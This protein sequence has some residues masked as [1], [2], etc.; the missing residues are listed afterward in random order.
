[1]NISNLDLSQIEENSA[2]AA[3][4]LK[5]LSNQQRL[6]ILA[7]LTQGELSVGE[8]E[9]RLEISQSSLSQH[10]ARLRSQ[11]VVEFRKQSTTVYYRL[12]DPK[13]L[14]ILE[15]LWGLYQPA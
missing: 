14:R 7:H 6:L 11:G 12:N 1:M 13:A 2:Q 10:L 5:L 8:L 4:F 3:N 15:T 9:S